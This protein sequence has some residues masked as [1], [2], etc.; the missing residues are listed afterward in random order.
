MSIKYLIRKQPRDFVWHD[1]FQDSALDWPK[2]YPGNKVWINVHEYKATLAG[3]ASYLRILI[4]GNHDCNLV[5]K[6]KPDGAHDL[7]RMIRQ[8]PKPL[9]FSALQRLGFRYSDDDQY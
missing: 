6:T 1:E 2:C 5:W 4:S 7:Q 3:D 8:L 9:G